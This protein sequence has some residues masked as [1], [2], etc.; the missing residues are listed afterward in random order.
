MPSYI[1]TQLLYLAGPL[2]AAARKSAA[3]NDLQIDILGKQRDSKTASSGALPIRRHVRSRQRAAGG[4]EG[5]P[6]AQS[7]RHLGALERRLLQL[8]Q[9]PYP[10]AYFWNPV[11]KG[12]KLAEDVDY[13]PQMP[14]SSKSSPTPPI[15]RPP[16]N[17]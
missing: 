4:R 8:R 2:G 12:C 5:S 11:G 9:H 6:A 14:R 7:R 3:K 13:S 1:S 10:M 16:T 15:P 17:G